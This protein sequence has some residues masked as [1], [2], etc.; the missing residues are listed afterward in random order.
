MDFRK[1]SLDKAASQRIWEPAMGLDSSGEGIMVIVT[2]QC[3]S[4]N[5]RMC[6]GSGTQNSVKISNSG[7]GSAR[8]PK[9]RPQG[10]NRGSFSHRPPGCEFVFLW[11]YLECV[12]TSH[13]HQ[14]QNIV[15]C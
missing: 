2:R 1:N 4:L 13:S 7:E 9:R 10:P 12:P 5:M 8:T 11:Q 14:K 15:K 6:P 3:G